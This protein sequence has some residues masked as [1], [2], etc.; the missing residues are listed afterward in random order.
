M[1]RSADEELKRLRR[2]RVTRGLIL[3][4]VALGAPAVINAVVARRAARLPRPRWGSTRHVEIDGRRLAFVH[5]PRSRRESA[6][7]MVLLHT[8]GPGHTGLLW[9]EA[10]ERLARGH[11]CFV[12]DWLGWGDSERKAQRYTARV[13]IDVLD[14]FLEEVVGEPAVVVAPHRAA[15]YAV[16]VALDAPELVA[17]LALV[18]P[19]GLGA[20]DRGDPVLHGLLRAPLLGTSALN[21]VTG[22]RALENHLRRETMFG[23][24]GLGEDVVEAMYRAS[25]LPG[26]SHALI[27]SLC[28]RLGHQLDAGFGGDVQQPL[29]LAWGRQATHPALETADLWLQEM[30]KADLEVFDGCRNLPHVERPAKFAAALTAF[31]ERQRFAA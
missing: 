25:H 9:R 18:A 14:R 20:E 15:A 6:P 4:G 24:E 8:F 28:G 23:A 16:Q 3:G 19:Q 29:W 22:E 12:P 27:D 13:Y 10:A 5:I 26:A 31:I 21:V 7:P 30:P 1:A 2:R 17:A 11:D